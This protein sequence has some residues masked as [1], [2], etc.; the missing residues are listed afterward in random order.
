MIVESVGIVE[1]VERDSWFQIQGSRS[2][3]ALPYR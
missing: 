1:S 3:A 2:K